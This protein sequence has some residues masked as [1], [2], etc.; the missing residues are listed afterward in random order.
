MMK[1]TGGGYKGWLPNIPA[2]DLTDEEVARFGREFL[3]R[4]GL[5][6]EV[7]PAGPEL[8]DIGGLGAARIE[9]LAAMGIFTVRDL[10]QADPAAI[11][12]ALDGANERMVKDW[13]KQARELLG[14]NDGR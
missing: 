5:Y 3:L 7:E 2:R 11:N 8:A 1:Y 12:A 14:E 6:E 9:A 13:Q 4:T 10:A